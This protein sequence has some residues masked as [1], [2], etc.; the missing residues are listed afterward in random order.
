MNIIVDIGHPGHVHYFKNVIRILINKGHKVLIIARDRDVIFDLLKKYNLDFIS[1]GSGK[2]SKFG[3][4]LYMFK[5][6]IFILKKSM[7]FKPNLFLSFSSPYA[8]Q[9]AK[10]LNKP[11]I[12]L[13]D[14]EHTDA[15]HSKFTYPF[16]SCILTPFN[17]KNSLGKNH[18][19][20]NSFIET[21]YLHNSWFRPNREN[22]RS[23]NLRKDEEFV[24]LRFVS[25][26]AHHDFGQEGLGMETKRNIINILKSKY[27]VFIS[28]ES[29]LPEEF[30]K[31]KIN[32]PV[33]KMHDA[34]SFAS[35]FIGESGTMASESVL[36]GTPAI[37]INS[38]PL[39][40]YLEFQ[41]K[42]ELLYHFSSSNG[43]EEFILKFIE[44]KDFKKFSN[45]KSIKMQKDF[46]NTT[47]FLVWF[48]EDF[49]NSLEIMRN[50]P[51]YQLKFL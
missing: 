14:T 42:K 50:N 4:I 47:E 7:L 22:L 31:Y 34:L 15:T 36:L 12:A 44:K 21:L 29:E 33:E 41:K 28:S 20:I 45:I 10:L 51:D 38:L 23:L 26:N 18:I 30:K 40:C 5:A 3:K 32:I 43:V 39:M 13:N 27:K 1:R 19:R 6:D 35:I 49:P 8:A 9:V 24:I 17:Y 25:W 46:I 48:I 37:Y 11:H 2:N 16:S